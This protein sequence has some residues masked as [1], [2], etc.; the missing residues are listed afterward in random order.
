LQLGQCR[1]HHGDQKRACG[2]RPGVRIGAAPSRTGC[3][4]RPRTAG[5]ASPTPSSKRITSSTRPGLYEAL[6]LSPRKAGL[7]STSPSPAPCKVFETLEGTCSVKNAPLGESRALAVDYESLQPDAPA[8]VAT[9]TFLPPDARRIKGYELMASPTLYSG[10]TV[11]ARVVADAKT[12]S[13][14]HV[15][16]L[17]RSMRKTTSSSRSTDRKRRSRP[18]RRTSLSGKFR[19]HRE[20]RLRSLASR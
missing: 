3:T 13:P 11:R 8:R 2:H 12:P 7:A 10:Q 15:A 9:W 18:V 4:C 20:P 16:S 5:A 6:R 19:T 14:S 17:S 1:L